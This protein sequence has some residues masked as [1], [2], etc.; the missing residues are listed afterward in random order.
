MKKPYSKNREPIMFAAYPES[1]KDRAAVIVN[2]LSGRY[3]VYYTSSFDKRDRRVLSKAAAFVLIFGKTG[4]AAE[5][6][7]AAAVGT[8][9]PVI[10]VMLE[11]TDL[12]EELSLLLG[13]CQW[14]Q[15]EKYGSGEELAEAVASSPSLTAAKVT[16]EQKKAA[17][18]TVVFLALAALLAILA[19]IMLAVFNPFSGKKIDP[20]SLL[21]RLGLS[22]G[23]NSVRAVYIYG[24]RLY[25]NL[26]KD[27]AFEAGALTNDGP[28][29]LY[30]PVAGEFTGRGAIGDA[31]EF[32]ELINLTELS[33]CGNMI[34]DVSQISCFSKLKVLDLSYQHGPDNE[35]PDGFGT[36]LTGISA[37]TSLETLYL[38]DTNVTGGF[39]ELSAMP[40]FK[41]LVTSR[42]TLED[43]GIDAS[44]VLYEIVYIDRLVDGYESFKNALEDE[45]VHLIRVARGTAITVPAGD[46]LT[47]RAD[48]R[49]SGD[50]F[51]FTNYGDISIRGSWETGMAKYHN[52]GSVTVENGGFLSGGMK[53]THNHGTFT[54]EKGGIHELERG[55]EFIQESG[56]YT[57]RGTLGIWIGGA[58]TYNGGDLHNDGL[59]RVAFAEN[60]GWYSLGTFENTVAFARSFEG[61]G[62]VEEVE[63][64]YVGSAPI[65]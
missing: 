63:T 26:E 34:R 55:N 40:S 50:S 32:R 59:I 51:D 23:V 44:A 13:S 54:V 39:E 16:P 7:A 35:D 62:K 4:G 56:V 43:A 47:V 1:D 33:L 11:R 6:A 52:Y 31:S 15:R 25:K 58:Y 3:K 14:A 17:K 45:N 22:G 65:E 9:R 12:P 48:C 46:S 21:G 38:T 57:V 27:G 60:F 30:L 29:V 20:D 19:G 10:P 64:I 8:G 41:K 61:S 24:D 18:R 36:S 53:E 5:K 2:A 28:S 37:L 49:V 42:Y